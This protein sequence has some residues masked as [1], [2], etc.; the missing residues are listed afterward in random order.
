ML[1]EIGQGTRLIDDIGKLTEFGVQSAHIGLIKKTLVFTGG[2][3]NA[4]IKAKLKVV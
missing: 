3:Y 4:R 1:P 2:K